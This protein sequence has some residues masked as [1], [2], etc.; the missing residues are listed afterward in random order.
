MTENIGKALADGN[1]ECEVL[2]DLKK[3]FD[4][5][6]RQI[7]LAKLNHYGIRRV[8]NDWFKSYLSNLKQDVSINEYGLVLLL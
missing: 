6:D 7:L 3:A 8:S 1:I 2:V 5:V 4:T